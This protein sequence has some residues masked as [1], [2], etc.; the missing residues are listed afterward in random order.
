MATGETDMNTTTLAT[1][2]RWLSVVVA[3]LAS[4][5]LVPS[6]AAETVLILKNEFIQKYYKNRATIEVYYLI[7]KAHKKLNPASRDADIH[8]AGAGA[9]VDAERLLR[10]LR[11]VH[12]WPE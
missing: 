3:G 12:R 5:F 2:R 10:F 8:V 7:D 4:A 1:H 6:A 9:L 11:L